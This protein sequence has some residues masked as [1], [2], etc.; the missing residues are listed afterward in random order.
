MPLCNRVNPFGTLHAT[1]ARGLFTGNRGVIHD[2]QTRT[3]LNRRWTSKAWI[4]CELHWKGKRRDVWGRNGRG[5]GAGWTE[6]FFLDEVTALAAGHRP[7]FACRREAAT[8]FVAASRTGIDEPRLGVR[9]LDGRL[10]G[11]RHVSGGRGPVLEPED[12]TSLPDG[13]V[14]AVGSLAIAVHDGMLLPWSHEGYASPIEVSALD[15]ADIRLLTPVSTL[16]ALRGGYRPVWHET[17][18]A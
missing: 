15:P 7:C 8:S 4:I 13:A 5:G 9:E 18:R 6:L 17:A 3:L 2:P 10:H 12:V 1:Q 11:E 16:A 14:I